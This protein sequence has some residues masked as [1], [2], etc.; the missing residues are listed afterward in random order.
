MKRKIF[1]L[2]IIMFFSFLLSADLIDI[3]KSGKI[4][5]VPDSKF[6]KGTE[7]DMYFP[8]GIKDIAFTK[9]GSFFVTAMGGTSH[10]V[11][12][13]DKD[14]NFIKKFGRKG[15]G[16]GDLYHPGNLSILDNKYLLIGE[17]ATSRRISVFDLNG[18]FVKV[19]KTKDSV[20]DVV[21][22]KN[23]K[24]AILTL[25]FKE[26]KGVLVK[27]F[28]VWLRNIKT[29]AEKKIRTYS[30]AEIMSPLK[31]GSFYGKVCMEGI[32]GGDLILGFS[33]Q[34]RIEILSSNGK[35]FS[36]INLGYKRRDVNEKEKRYF[37]KNMKEIL[38]KM[39]NK[40]R[41]EIV[42]KLLNKVKY[43]KYGPCYN[44]MIVDGMGNILVLR[45]DTVFSSKEYETK[46][47][48][49]KGKSI[50]TIK[51][52]RKDNPE[53]FGIIRFYQNYVYYFDK[54]DEILKRAIIK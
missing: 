14:G 49:N 16:P 36:N 39:R 53:Y 51:I 24:I 29:G 47:F 5:L 8:R 7:W 1:M 40:R 35:V 20:F 4:K 41:T 34:N 26:N 23:N 50:G 33:S 54:E 13:F 11:F 19:I 32:K 48:T 30:E 15:R 22:L 43:P 9:D 6:G 3:Y 38:K 44:K 2:S 27:S 28:K 12:K 46:I 37:C 18:N 21:G 52:E 17:Y 42:K 31:P 45:G 10:S 25:K